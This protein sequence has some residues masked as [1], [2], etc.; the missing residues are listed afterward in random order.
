[1]SSR[2]D[3]ASYRQAVGCVNVV[4]WLEPRVFGCTWAI[5]LQEVCDI[6]LAISG[7]HSNVGY[8]RALT[9]ANLFCRIVAIKV[10]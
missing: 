3:P 2:C 5:G 9:A 7:C 4:R 8:F 10:G 1:M 6:T